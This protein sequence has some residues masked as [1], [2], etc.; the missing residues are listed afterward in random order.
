V[1]K[2][3]YCRGVTAEDSLAHG[4]LTEVVL[5]LLWLV[6]QSRETVT[7]CVPWG[8]HMLSVSQR[9]RHG[10]ER[11][12]GSHIRPSSHCC[13]YVL[14]KHDTKSCDRVFSVTVLYSGGSGFK[15]WPRRPAILRYLWFSLVHVSK[16][17]DSTVN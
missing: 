12:V 14:L 2:P 1:P 15:S 10:L 4:K 7:R 8:N 16:C 5:S 13:M 11:S 17:Q 3:F 9:R 6:I